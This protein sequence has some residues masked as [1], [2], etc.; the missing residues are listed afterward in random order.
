MVAGMEVDE[1]K[2][3]KAKK[4]RKWTTNWLDVNIH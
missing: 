2:E 4:G 1:S 3:T